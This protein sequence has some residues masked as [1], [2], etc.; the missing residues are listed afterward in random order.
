M[1][2]FEYYSVPMRRIVLHWN[3]TIRRL[4][5]TAGWFATGWK[6][7]RSTHKITGNT[8]NLFILSPFLTYIITST[9]IKVTK[10]LFSAIIQTPCEFFVRAGLRSTLRILTL[11]CRH[12][13][14]GQSPWTRY[15]YIQNQKNSYTE[16]PST[17]G[18]GTT[19]L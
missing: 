8:L 4:H 7:S 17:H 14:C 15:L 16:K 18:V 5:S 3:I 1:L 6:H 19:S 12:H 9:N 2:H 11:P 13:F 10:F